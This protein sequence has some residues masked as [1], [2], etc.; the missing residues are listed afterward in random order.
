MSSSIISGRYQY[1]KHEEMDKYLQDIGL[2]FILRKAILLSSPTIEFII[3]DNIMT[4]RIT[5]FFVKNESTFNIGEEYDEKWPGFVLKSVSTIVN[6]REVNTDSVAIISK[7]DR[8]GRRYFFDDDGCV[9][10]VTHAKT[11]ITA[12]R[13]YRRIK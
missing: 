6:E 4:I 2:N 1:Y 3:E 11:N 13:Y 10:Y 8:A 9:E 5:S 7:S 12:K